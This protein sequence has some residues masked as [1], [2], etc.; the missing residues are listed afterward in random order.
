MTKSAFIHSIQKYIWESCEIR[1]WL[2]IYTNLSSGTLKI[3]KSRTDNIFNT[4]SLI[5]RKIF[6]SGRI[7][8]PAK[9]KAIL[10]CSYCPSAPFWPW[11]TS[12]HD[13]YF[14][15]VKDISLIKNPAA[16]I[17]LEDN[18]KSILGSHVYQGSF[19]AILMIK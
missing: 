6:V 4:I 2:G 12:G 7:L 13:T 14:P 5:L 15:F 8:F 1:T 17:K 16:C 19:I 3:T 18:K 9:S 10:I 11:L